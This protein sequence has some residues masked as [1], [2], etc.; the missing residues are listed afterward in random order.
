MY[1]DFLSTI[2]G[3]N[4]L[5]PIMQRAKNDN[6][7]LRALPVYDNDSQGIPVH[8]YMM[9]VNKPKKDD[10]LWNTVVREETRLFKVIETDCFFTKM[11]KQ[12]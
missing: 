1:L 3:Q 12:L 11:R 4:R 6:S 8:V 2:D 5:N 10:C 7:V 9:K